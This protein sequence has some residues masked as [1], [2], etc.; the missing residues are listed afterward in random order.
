M[1]NLDKSKIMLISIA[2]RTLGHLWTSHYL[3]ILEIVIF[4]ALGHYFG[5]HGG[6]QHA[7]PRCSYISCE[8]TWAASKIIEANL[9]T[10]PT[11]WGYLTVGS[12]EAFSFLLL[13][14]I[15]LLVLLLLLLVVVVLLLVVVELVLVLGAA[16]AA[17]GA[18]VVVVAVMVG[19]LLQRVPA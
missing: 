17:E 19:G 18:G 1:V 2:W 7:P 6:T 9:A 5:L 10:S 15:L 3:M 13:L 14:L 8:Q 11:V 12:L 16:T 4:R